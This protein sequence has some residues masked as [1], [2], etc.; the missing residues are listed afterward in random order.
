LPDFVADKLPSDFGF[1]SHIKN[2][3]VVE[4]SVTVLQTYIKN[5]SQLFIYDLAG[6]VLGIALLTS[7]LFFT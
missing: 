2:E 5:E 4:A 6:T 1:A 3:N 7:A